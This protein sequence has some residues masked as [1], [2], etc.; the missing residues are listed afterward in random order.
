MA[1][2]ASPFDVK[3]FVGTDIVWDGNHEFWLWVGFR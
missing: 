2:C 3:I 1:D